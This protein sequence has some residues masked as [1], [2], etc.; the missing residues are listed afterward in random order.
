MFFL[1]AGNRDAHRNAHCL[2]GVTTERGGNAVARPLESNR[3]QVRTMGGTA[4]PLIPLQ[5]P[6]RQQGLE[7]D[8]RV[9]EEIHQRPRCPL[10]AARVRVAAAVERFGNVLVGRDALGA[11]VTDLLQGL[12]DD[13]LLRLGLV[14]AGF[15][16]GPVVPVSAASP[17]RVSRRDGP[18]CC[19]I[20]IKVRPGALSSRLRRRW[21]SA[22]GRR[23]GGNR[24]GSRMR[25]APRG[26]PPSRACAPFRS[27]AFPSAFR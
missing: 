1:A 9:G 3:Q 15:G 23:C 12:A 10:V 2:N 7:L 25:R 21:S 19:V 18:V 6:A 11:Q 17:G 5:A 14:A 13:L 20:S 26:Q 24:R 27:P 4:P 22:T 8:V 16:H